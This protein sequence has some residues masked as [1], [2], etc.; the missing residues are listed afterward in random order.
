MITTSHYNY[1]TQEKK[2]IGIAEL[3]LWKVKP[4]G[5][6]CK[7]GGVREL[8]RITSDCADSFAAVTWLPAILPRLDVVFSSNSQEVL[9]CFVV[10]LVQMDNLVNHLLYFR[11]HLLFESPVALS[12]PQASVIFAVY[13]FYKWWVLVLRSS[14]YFVFFVNAVPLKLTYV[15]ETFFS[16]L[17]A[18]LYRY[19][20]NFQWYNV[21]L[22][23]A[24]SEKKV[25]L[26]SYR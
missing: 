11:G 23:T 4:V 20:C 1:V 25:S 16:N 24:S 9:R 13:F 14:N 18:Q 21:S 7:C 2:V 10:H 5:P 15:N 8:A 22:M 12:V 19:M 6:L 26:R 3:I 17:M